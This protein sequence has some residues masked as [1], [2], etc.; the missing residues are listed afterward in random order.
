MCAI[1]LEVFESPD[2][3][4]SRTSVVLDQGAL[5]DIRMLAYEQGYTAGWD[6]AAAAQTDDQSRIKADFGRN[7]QSLGFTF[8]EART[9]VLRAIRPLLHQ[10]I[11]CLLPELAR[12]ALP[13]VALEVLMPLADE[14]ADAPVTL[15]LNPASRAVVQALLEQATGLPLTVIEEPTLGEGQVYL[16]L[17]DIE[18]RIDLDRATADI[19][20][21]ARDFFD[22]TEKDQ[23]YG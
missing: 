6:D 2:A 11:T 16:R 7:L 18:T 15:V 9:H 12:E 1:R 19:A 21:A 10:I 5:E 20:R 3:P 8:Q 23:R 17:G 4:L 13:S 14:M 22:L